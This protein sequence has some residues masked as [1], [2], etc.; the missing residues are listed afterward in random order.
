MAYDGHLAC[1]NSLIEIG[2]KSAEAF[3]KVLAL[4]ESK[5]RAVPALNRVDYQRNLMQERRAR[6][7]K[8]LELHERS[9]KRIRNTQER[10]TLTAQLQKRWSKAQAEYLKSKGKLSW[11]ERNAARQE[12]WA[13]I[14][15]KLDADLK[16]KE[17]QTA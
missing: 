11:K 13:D 4:I 3:E 15:A 2:L 17:R 7:S 5:R 9:G 1:L 14:D 10:Q 6:V 12:F 8:A 16:T